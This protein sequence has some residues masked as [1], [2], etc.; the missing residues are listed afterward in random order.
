MKILSKNEVSTGMK[1]TQLLIIAG[2]VVQAFIGVPVQGKESP[3]N[4]P[5]KFQ[6]EKLGP[7]RYRIPQTEVYRLLGSMAFLSGQARLRPV[8]RNK[9]VAGYQIYKI[10]SGSVFEQLGLQNKDRLTHLNG[11]P[12]DGPR[13]QKQI[14][15]EL[16]KTNL[17]VVKLRRKG[18]TLSL[19]Y[20]LGSPP[21]PKPPA[22][23][24]NKALKPAAAQQK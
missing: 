2:L 8:I 16:N 10:R 12:L 21:K 13:R 5:Q 19:S 6:I 11:I 17:M 9:V 15:A 4:P 23:A 3:K 22:P 14:L 1:R 20:L 18:K 7:T 24:E